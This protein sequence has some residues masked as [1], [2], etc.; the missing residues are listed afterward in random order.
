MYIK[1]I[2]QS[3]DSDTILDLLHGFL[4]PEG[5]EKRFDDVEKAVLQNFLECFLE[6]YAEILADFTQNYFRGDDI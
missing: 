2:L 1:N 6:E 5:E 3:G 4:S